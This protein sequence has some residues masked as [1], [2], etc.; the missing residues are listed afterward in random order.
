MKAGYDWS[1][2]TIGGGSSNVSP[3]PFIGGMR[4]EGYA[5]LE[6]D[7]IDACNDA[8]TQGGQDVPG[9][10][11]TGNFL[12]E[13]RKKEK[14]ATVKLQSMQKQVNQSIKILQGDHLKVAGDYKNQSVN[15]LKQLASYEN[16]K[17]KLLK[18]GRELETLNA[19]KEDSH[20]SKNSMGMGYYLW[21]TLAISVLGMAIV[22][23]K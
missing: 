22:K 19:L 15:L 23:I 8:G 4:R 7:M 18:S 5:P 6:G 17:H 3:E 14:A 13:N 2:W 1:H 9:V 12:V 21:L 11:P 16:A 20:L 10:Q